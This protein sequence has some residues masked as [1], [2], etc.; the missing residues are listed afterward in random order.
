[1]VFKED[2]NKT[3]LENSQKNL[4][5]IR[6]FCLAILK[7]FKEKRKLSMNSIRFCISLDFEK[8]IDSI[9]KDLYSNK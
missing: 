2:K 7:M 3:F 1:M 6:K 5:I 9:I 4:N 8:E